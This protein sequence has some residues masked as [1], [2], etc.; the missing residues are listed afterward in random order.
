MPVMGGNSD[1]RPFPNAARFV[2]SRRRYMWALVFSGAMTLFF[3][4]LWIADPDP[5]PGLS[6]LAVRLSVP[7]AAVSGIVFLELLGQAVRGPF[8]V[9]QDGMYN[10][11][12]WRRS[13]REF[14]W[15][16]VVR[17]V[18]T[19]HPLMGQRLTFVMADGRRSV[20]PLQLLEDPKLFEELAASFRDGSNG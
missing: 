8:R 14:T 19:E 15:S 20:V 4:W 6:G 2:I 17:T 1:D 9:S 5:R 11:V 16:E 3:V 12:P 10:P 7:L 18:R 13:L